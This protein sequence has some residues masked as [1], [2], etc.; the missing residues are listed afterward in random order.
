MAVREQGLTDSKEAEHLGLEELAVVLGSKRRCVI[1]VLEED[2]VEDRQVLR[3]NSQ[4][5]QTL[6][7]GKKLG[8]Q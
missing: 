3:A 8:F 1:V 4:H 7:E 2:V 6:A 5:F